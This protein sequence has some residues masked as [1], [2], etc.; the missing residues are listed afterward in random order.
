MKMTFTTLPA[1]A[2]ALLLAACSSAPLRPDMAA[3]AVPLDDDRADMLAIIRSAGSDVDGSIQVQ[4]LRDAAV[5]GLVEQ[6]DAAS[7]AGD[8]DAAA[9]ALDEALQITGDAPDLLQEL[10]EVEIARGNWL[11][12]EVLAVRSWSSGPRVGALCMRNWQTAAEVR[13]VLQD[14]V[15]RDKALARKKACAVAPPVRR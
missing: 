14:T 8:F 6:A 13:R 7:R 9:Q 4:P 15:E 5:T 11:Q 10:A 3:Q 1:V 2:A 12:A